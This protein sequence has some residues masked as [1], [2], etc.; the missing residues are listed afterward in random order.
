MKAPIRQFNDEIRTCV[1]PDDSANSDWFEMDQGLWQECLP[2]LLLLFNIFFAAVLTV[3][4]QT[5]SEGTV[6]LA[7]L[8][9]LKELPTLMGPESAMD[10][11]RHAAWGLLYA[12]DACVVSR[13]TWELSKMIKAIVEACRVFALTVSVKKT[14]NICMPPPR[15]PRTTIRVEVVGQTYKQ[16]Q[17]FATRRHRNS[18]HVR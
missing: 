6:I 16:V 7:E 10:Y 14:E 5:F 9:H 8:A 17:F 3:I 18:G 11:V 13:S 2:S 15:T 1:R 4:P 12:D